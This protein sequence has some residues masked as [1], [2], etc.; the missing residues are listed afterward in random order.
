VLALAGKRT[1]LPLQGRDAGSA[2]L[3]RGLPQARW[4]HLATHGFFADR[5]FRSALELNEADYQ[6]A[7][8][9]V[10]GVRERQGAGMRSPLVL[11][12]LVLAGANLA[13]HDDAIVTAEALVGLDLSK[14]ELAVMSACETGL[15]DVAGGEGVFG[16]QRAFHLAGTR[17]VVASL[18]KVDDAATA[19][20]M[21]LFY[22][23]LWQKDL[24][25]LE[26]LAE[27]QRYLYRHPK[28]LPVLAKRRGLDFDQEVSRPSEAQAGE[29][30][31]VKLWAGFVLSGPGR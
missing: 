1:T 21:G 28:Q 13:G 20:L 23:N 4:A 25:P 8:D 30:S 11:S 16:L 15:G 5:T 10:R 27:A 17:N 19:V 31:A 6:A 12:G 26:A 29:R 9:R 14:L 2:Q 22:R 7:R 24:P 3:L 18:W